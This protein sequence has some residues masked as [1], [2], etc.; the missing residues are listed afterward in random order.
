VRVW[1][2]LVTMGLTGCAHVATLRPAP[3]GALEVE[4][5]MGGPT[6][7]QGTV[8]V[9]ATLTSLGARYG[10]HER[11]DIQAHFY[12]TAALLGVMGLDVGTSVLALKGDKA[13]PDVTGTVRLFGFT[14]FK[15]TFRPNLQL[16]AVASWRLFNRIAPYLGVDWLIEGPHWGVAM[17]LQGIF[18]RFTVQL[19]AKWFGVGQDVRSIVV[20]WLSP[21]DIG[22]LGVQ[23]GLSYRFGGD[24]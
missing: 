8:A 14:D 2:L 23:L 21:N 11:A 22:T 20:E 4:L 1:A 18:G 3:K 6:L 19:E 12:P 15:R 24:S 16:G 7:K 17:G 13:I 5:S 9:P 10:V